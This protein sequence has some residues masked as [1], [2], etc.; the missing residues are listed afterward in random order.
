MSHQNGMY[1]VRNI[2]SNCSIFVWWQVV[3]RLI[4]VIILKHIEI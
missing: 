4:L 2:V 3:T 1:S